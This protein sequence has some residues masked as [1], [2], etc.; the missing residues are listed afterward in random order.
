MF[1]LDTDTLSLLFRNHPQVLERFQ[2]HRPDEKVTISILTR[3][4]ILRG[5]FDALIKA[6]TKDEWLRAQTRLKE[7]DDRL[8]AWEIIPITE[9]AADQFERLRATKKLRK[10]GRGDLLIACIALANKATLVTRNTKDFKLIPGLK[11]ENW[12]D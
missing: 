9:A 10:A 2:R 3:V 11:L 4:E 8:A 7:D 1:L 6:A 5:R 12:A